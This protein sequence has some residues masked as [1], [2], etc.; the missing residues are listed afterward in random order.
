MKKS[1]KNKKV[2]KVMK[3]YKDKKLKSSSWKKVTNRKQAI[4]IAL[5]EA[6][7]KAKKKGKYGKWKKK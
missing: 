6:T 3:E 7:R 1:A 4:A 5:S 2:W